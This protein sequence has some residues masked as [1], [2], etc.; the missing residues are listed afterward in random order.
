MIHRHVVGYVSGLLDVAIANGSTLANAGELFEGPVTFDAALKLH[1]VKAVLPTVLTTK[2]MQLSLPKGFHQRALV[3][4][5][6]TEGQILDFADGELSKIHQGRQNPGEMRVKMNALLKNLDYHPEPGKEGTIQDLRT[7]ARQNIIINT[8]LATTRG[9]ANAIH[10]NDPDLVDEF[11]ALELV[12]GG[13]RLHQRGSDFYKPG[14]DGSAG[15][16][17]RWQDALD[18]AGDDRAQAVFDSTGRMIALLSSPV[19]QALGDGAG[20]HQDS[21]RMPFAPFAWESGMTQ[22]QVDR[23]ECVAIGLI[24]P[25]EDT[26]PM[27]LPGYNEAFQQAPGIDNPSILDMVLEIIGDAGHINPAGNIGLV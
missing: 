22:R 7:L 20:G 12:R 25:G 27:D 4:A 9:F 19:W 15:W 8:N 13:W 6:V 2:E 17:E 26:E 11:P 16:L 18:E 1:D 21:L 5:Q 10:R 24:D 14:T 23:D 3:S